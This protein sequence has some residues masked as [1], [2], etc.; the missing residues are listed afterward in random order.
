MRRGEAESD[1]A[2]PPSAAGVSHE[3][4]A[5]GFVVTRLAPVII[6]GRY[7]L[8]Q[9]LDR[10]PTSEV[11]LA[12]DQAVDRAVVVKLL[13]PAVDSDPGFGERF[14]AAAQAAAGLDHP[15]IVKVDDW[16]DANDTWFLVMEHVEGESLAELLAHEGRLPAD[17]AA[18]IA[19]DIASALDHA[20]RNGG[21]VHRDVKPGNILLTRDGTVEVTDF[22]IAR[23]VSDV[24]DQD[25]TQT[26]SVM[27]TAAYFSP[28]QARGAD[29]DARSDVYSLGCVLYEMLVG[30]PPFTGAN[31]LAI[32]YKHVQEAP[33]APR[34]VDPALP[35]TLEAIVLKCLAKTP[36]NRYP[37]AR[38]L[39]ADLRRYLEGARLATDPAPAPPVAAPVAIPADPDATIVM[40]PVADAPPTGAGDRTTTIFPAHFA[41]GGHRDHRDDGDHGGYDDD[42]D[43]EGDDSPRS[44]AVVAVLVA[45]VLVLVGMLFLV[46]KSNISGG[47]EPA[48][49]AGDVTVPR[50][51]GMPQ[52]D[53]VAAL[54]Q[55]DLVSTVETAADDTVAAGAVIS[56][57]PGANET[58]APGTE[59]TLTVSSGPGTIPV[60][61]LAGKTLDDAIEIVTD[62]GLVPS[63]KQVESD[64][65]AEG[66][67]IGT[68]PAAGTS[69]TSGA[70]IEIQVSAK[71]SATGVPDVTGQP[72]DQAR[73][74]LEGAG[75]QVRVTDQPIR[76]RR[77]D[78][79]VLG[80]N[81]PPGTPVPAGST[82]DIVVGR[83]GDRGE[84]PEFPELPELPGFPGQDDNGNG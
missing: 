78:G 16:G 29:V 54:D 21:I 52:A 60:P 69:T 27:G 76:H 19:A 47:D 32:A 59:I 84:F 46:A 74:T 28:E 68:N 2:R 18:E 66:L 31:A 13:V 23:A 35:E 26:G 64:T 80:Q 55:A 75:F 24:P 8:Q 11:Y 33:V 6:N 77:R 20:H 41:R 42:Y 10:G 25:L 9:R 56:Q 1:G 81:P 70:A 12:R 43:D 51:I 62:L 14:Q 45:V 71:P 5:G 63:P 30:Q 39:R 34:R 37:S 65:V 67:V 4:G 7:E 49:D 57:D 38:D 82:I 17:R 15:N 48:Q 22:G 44:Y 40:A 50:V 61:D 53:A 79:I 58:V 73:A 72:E 83:A 3:V 36:A